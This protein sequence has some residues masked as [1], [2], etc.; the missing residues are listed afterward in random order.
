MKKII[1][2]LLILPILGAGAVYAAEVFVSATVPAWFDC[3]IEG[4]DL[5]CRT[6]A[7]KIL[8]NGAQCK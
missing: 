7:Q 5:V 8:I 6:N 4:F 2:L 1:F 3:R